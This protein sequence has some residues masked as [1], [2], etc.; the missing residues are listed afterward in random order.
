MLYLFAVD[1]T[2]CY[3]PYPSP[4]FRNARV[5][6]CSYV[7]WFPRIGRLYCIVYYPFL[8]M[9]VDCCVVYFGGDSLYSLCVTLVLLLMIS[10]VIAIVVFIVM[11]VPLSIMFFLVSCWLLIVWMWVVAIGN[12]RVYSRLIVCASS[13]FILFVAFFFCVV[14]FFRSVLVF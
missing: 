1:S 5:H 8:D 10:I 9:Y 12:L 14:V 13:M 2:G 6:D 11:V 4:P 3:C 7:N